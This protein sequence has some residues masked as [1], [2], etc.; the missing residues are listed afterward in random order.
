MNHQ[1][2]QLPQA[3]V[4]GH[5]H[6]IAHSVQKMRE[7]SLFRALKPLLDVPMVRRSWIHSVP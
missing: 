3:L 1:V 5:T 4:A 2:S 6:T 7:R